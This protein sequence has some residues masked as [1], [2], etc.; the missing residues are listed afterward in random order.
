[1]IFDEDMNGMTSDAGMSTDETP[2]TEEATEETSAPAEETPS[3][4][5]GM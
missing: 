2:A 4:E 5:A 1:M 3:E